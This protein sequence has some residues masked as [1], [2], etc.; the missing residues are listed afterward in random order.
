[1]FVRTQHMKYILRLYLLVCCFVALTGADLMG[2]V[3][4]PGKKNYT[5]FTTN[6]AAPIAPAVYQ[7][8]LADYADHPEFGKIPYLSGCSDCMEDLSKRTLDTRHLIKADEP[9]VFYIQKGYG[10]IHFKDEQDRFLSIDPR[11]RPAQLGEA[12]IYHSPGQETPLTIDNINGFT[13]MAFRNGQEPILNH[14]DVKLSYRQGRNTQPLG[15]LQTDLSRMT[16]GDDGVRHPNV[17]P[18]MDRVIEVAN[19]F[20]KTNYILNSRPTAFAPAGEMIFTERLTLP[21]NSIIVRGDGYEQNDVWI[22]DLVIRHLSGRGLATIRGPYMY[23]A[24]GQEADLGFTFSYDGTTALVHVHVPTSWLLEQNRAYPVTIDPLV[25][26]ITNWTDAANNNQPFKFNSQQASCPPAGGWNYLWCSNI[27][28]FGLPP[29]ATIDRENGVSFLFRFFNTLGNANRNARFQFEFPGVGNCSSVSSVIYSCGLDNPGAIASCQTQDE[30][31]NFSYSPLPNAGTC[32]EPSCD[33]IFL[34]LNMKGS[35]CG[36]RSGSE[37]C[38]NSCFKVEDNDF[39]VQVRGRT[40][41]PAITTSNVVNICVG[42]RISF[43]SDAQNG[44]PFQN[45]QPYLYRWV[46]NGREVGTGSIYTYE[47]KSIGLDSLKQVV[48]DACAAAFT[49]TFAITVRSGPAVVVD[50][51]KNGCVGANNGE[52]ALTV[53]DNQQSLANVI[54]S[55]KCNSLLLKTKRIVPKGFSGST[56]PALD[57]SPFKATLVDKRSQM[58]YPLTALKD[59]LPP[60]ARITRLS[61]TVTTKSYSSV[62]SNFTIRMGAP[63]PANRTTFSGRPQ[64]INTGM[65]TVFS[66]PAFTTDGGLNTIELDNGYVWDGQS[67]IIV[68]MSFD[69]S[70]IG[71]GDDI[72][73]VIRDGQN[74]VMIH[75]TARNSFNLPLDSLPAVFRDERLDIRFGYCDIGYIWTTQAQNQPET[76]I[77]TVPPRVGAEDTVLLKPATYTFAYSDRFGC[78]VE[79][80]FIID[81]KPLQLQIDACRDSASQKV[82]LRPSKGRP[83]YSFSLDQMTWFTDTLMTHK[84]GGNL[85][86]YL[87]DSSN[88]QP[89]PSFSATVDPPIEYRLAF[90]TISCHGLSDGAIKVQSPLASMGYRFSLTG[91]SFKDTAVVINRDTQAS[92]DFT[93][94]PAG[95]YRIRIIPNAKPACYAVV[96]TVLPDVPRL[97]AG[98]AAE[99]DTLCWDA[100]NGTINSLTTVGGK[101]PYTY[102][103]TDTAIAPPT[104][105][106]TTATKWVNLKPDSHFVWVKDRSGCI[107]TAMIR[108]VQLTKTVLDAAATRASIRGESCTGLQNGAITATITGGQAPHTY[109]LTGPTQLTNT[110]GIFAG[111]APGNYSLRVQDADTCGADPS[112]FNFVINP[113][114]TLEFHPDSTTIT[115]VSCNGKEDGVIQMAPRPGPSVFNYNVKYV[116]DGRTDSVSLPLQSSD[117]AF[118]IDS[119]GP[120]TYDIRL[121]TGPCSISTD[122]TITQPSPIT[123]DLEATSNLP[124]WNSTTGHIRVRNVNGGTIPHLFARNDTTIAPAVG[125]FSSQTDFNGLRPGKYRV[126]VRDA[127]GCLKDS[128][129][130]ITSPVRTTLD[131]LETRKAVK[132]ISCTGFTDGIIRAVVRLGTGPYTFILE[133]AAGTPVTNTNGLFTGLT[134]NKYTLR[135][136]DGPNCTVD[137][138]EMEIDIADVPGFTLSLDSLR[139]QNVRCAG[140]ADGS[141]RVFA[142]GIPNGNKYSLRFYDLSRTDSTVVD[143]LAYNEGRTFD[144]LKPGNYRIRLFFRSC[145]ISDTVT[146]TQ[147]DTLLWSTVTADSIRYTPLLECSNS[148]NGKITLKR[149]SIQGG[150]G[151]YKVSIRDTNF[152]AFSGDSIVFDTLSAGTYT[153]TIRDSLGCISPTPR[154]LTIRARPPVVINSINSTAVRCFGGADG[155]ITIS[156]SGRSD[157]TS[158]LVEYKRT[159]GTTWTT[160]TGSSR[161]RI[162][163]LAAQAGG[164]SYDVRLSDVNSLCPADVKSIEVI[165]PARLTLASQATPKPSSCFDDRN[166]GS[167]A[168]RLSGGTPPYRYELKFDS[169]AFDQSWT[170]ATG[171][172]INVNNL[173]PNRYKLQLTDVNGCT[174]IAVESIVVDAGPRPQLTAVTPIAVCVSRSSDTLQLQLGSGS[175]SGG[176]WVSTRGNHVQQSDNLGIFN[177]SLVQPSG[178]NGIWGTYP[179]VYQFGPNCRSAERLV[180]LQGAE[181]EDEF[182]LCQSDTTYQPMSIFPTGGRWANALSNS[183]ALPLDSISG[184]VRFAGVKPGTYHSMYSTTQN[185]LTCTDSIQYRVLFQPN[186]AYVLSPLHSPNIGAYY[187]KKD[188]IFRDNTA[189]DSATSLNYTWDFG[190]QSPIETDSSVTHQFEREAI[191]LVKYRVENSRHPECFDTTSFSLKVVVE[192]DLNIPSVITP[193]G[194]GIN[195]RLEIVTPPDHRVEMVISDRTGQRVFVYGENNGFWDGSRDGSKLTEGVYFYFYRIKNQITGNTIERS[196]SITIMR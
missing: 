159:D 103:L 115:Q 172:N 166:D 50:L 178:Q 52:I 8:N 102:A 60:G 156:A 87:R 168:A 97:V 24:N 82:R 35:S 152:R 9:Q 167:I 164:L 36:C 109:T 18:G 91:R 147:P 134:P 129:W 13:R 69:N 128:L 119:L 116:V 32:I 155:T 153:V 62:F 29:Q 96:D 6:A 117:V 99:D 138:G 101:T 130:T 53:R 185:G 34:P 22:G 173:A 4:S 55:N 72:V 88:C 184:E 12:H 180:H 163:N 21:E 61:F 132:G 186:I 48:S 86:L 183:T 98:A 140:G 182:S 118:T 31:G 124:C 19:G 137:P 95:R 64:F 187:V 54:T 126:W 176:Q 41:E 20:H 33:T 189:R 27:I 135:V 188:V 77:I 1:V 146:I 68:E 5:R 7:K 26:K 100:T 17:Y 161:F 190:D 131:T 143:S 42:E 66:R 94:L 120:G 56:S 78:Y 23:D 107:D 165:E 104:G 174:P 121:Y 25:D 59:S 151:P 114:V 196:G 149:S 38:R 144:N 3:F 90:D 127:N 150:V 93:G 148:T 40:L 39:R 169:L 112:L 71:D 141:F 11:L 92:G 37:N 162:T 76:S 75:N 2:Q 10:P 89:Y 79:D 70:V 170:N 14:H 81:P 15:I 16:A 83:P 113:G 47:A 30:N 110:T 142:N 160:N 192:L 125:A 73:N 28:N 45:G 136:T 80:T 74:N 157:T 65:Y 46:L 158:Y 194:D 175:P 108:I 43:T 84:Q 145:E 51:V 181:V 58:L 111:L 171:D 49:Q 177:V 63:T 191:Y 122:V 85:T 106:F 105:A 57:G 44:V 193:N 123:F 133:P 179:V 67:G 195:D 154:Q 139:L